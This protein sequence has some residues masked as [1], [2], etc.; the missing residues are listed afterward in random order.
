MRWNI[1]S[2]GKAYAQADAFVVSIPK[3]GRTWFRVLFDAYACARAGVPIETGDEVLVGLGLPRIRFTHDR[4]EDRTSRWWDRVR[5]KHLVARTQSGKPIV[6]LVRDPRD[7][8]VSLYH[9]LSKRDRRFEGDV[10]AF[11]RHPTFGVG[12]VVD[13]MNGWW[14]EW[15]EAANVVLVRYEDARSDTVG[16]L[17]T[18]TEHLGFGP[19]DDAALA[20][21]EE[22]ARFDNMQKLESSGSFREGYL[23]PGDAQDVNSFKVRR[24]KVGGYRDEL[25]DADVT[26][27]DQQ[28][29]RLHGVFGYGEAATAR[30]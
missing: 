21:A 20:A 14:D 11:L 6:L 27:L 22:Y 3:C 2:L 26:Y 16:A 15:R 13:V 1:S 30:A 8:I 19:A 12:L 9:H 17:R 28:C 23:K 4:W 24:G 29:A 25:E 10:S 18:M 7:V 5:G